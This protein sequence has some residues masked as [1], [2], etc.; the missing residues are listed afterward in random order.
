MT[1]HEHMWG[2]PITTGAPLVCKLPG[3]D[4]RKHLVGGR[5]RFAEY[6]QGERPPVGSFRVTAV[7]GDR[8]NVKHEQTGEAIFSVPGRWLCAEPP[9]VSV[10]ASR[11][12]APTSGGGVTEDTPAD[13]L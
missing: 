2:M 5:V 11:S 10:V 6:A 3:C 8:V 13:E 4:E 12:K 1:A 7:D 9:P